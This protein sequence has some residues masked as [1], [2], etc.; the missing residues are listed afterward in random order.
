VN[1]RYVIRQLGLLCIVLSLVMLAVAFAAALIWDKSTGPAR[2][3]FWAFLASA[4]LGSLLGGVMWYASQPD[5]KTLGR[6]EA[7]LLTALSWLVGAALSGLP[8]YLWTVLGSATG[9]RFSQPINCYFEAMSGLTTTGATTL[10]GIEQLPHTLLLWRAT[11]QW[12]GGLGIVVLFVAV[13]P[14]L[15]MVGKRMYSAEMAGPDKEGIT[16]QIHE[17]AQ[18]LWLIYLGLTVAETVALRLAGMT[19]FDAVCHTFATMA[20]GG[21]S[22]RDSSVGG[23]EPLSVTII[24][25]VFMVLAGVNFGLY[26]QLIHGRL[27]AI[28]ND[29]ELR[30]YLA[31]LLVASAVVVVSIADE[32]I[33]M[34]D[35]RQYEP[36]WGRAIRDGVFT[37]VSLQTATG[38]C[39]ADFDRWPFVAKAVLVM[40]M[41]VGGSA[42]STAGGI[43]VIRVV[44]AFKVMASELERAF[45]PNVVRPIK[46]GNATVTPEL[47]QGTIAFVLGWILLF[48]AGTGA[49]MVF[50][51]VG[52][53]DMTT[54]ATASITCLSNVGPGLA[55]VG[56]VENFA[57][58]SAPSKLALCLLMVTG[59]LGVFAIL[60]LL[61]PRFWRSR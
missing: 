30:A 35:G 31:I 54:A 2:H 28:W 25:I 16:P 23:Y 53:M 6:R 5:S 26:F 32:A 19:W 40:I 3:P 27:R 45:R 47:R 46:V 13:L 49:L 10:I 15:G 22:T 41:F 44:V 1:I 59:R 57:W 29:V 11:T 12:L 20:T 60:V 50:E 7:L 55:K 14:G 38:F 56:A 42:G 58:L 8:F 39:T 24:I 37:T 51:P 4:C 34:T 48:G 33:V 9:H 36:G 43:K 52:A 17:T 61:H 21:F 18:V